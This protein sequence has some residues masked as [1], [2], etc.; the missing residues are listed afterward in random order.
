VTV[1]FAPAGATLHA[2]SHLRI[3]AGIAGA[4][5]SD[6]TA[7]V[8]ITHPASRSGPAAN[9]PDADATPQDAHHSAS[10]H[11]HVCD[12]WQFLDH[13]LPAAALPDAAEFFAEP[14]RRTPL[15]RRVF[16][17]APWILPRA[18]PPR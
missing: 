10:D 4:V 12:E 3:S 11:C 5:A 1:V 13:V 8:A 17:E 6:A 2:M 7:S 15:P 16:A 9:A 18:P 14:P